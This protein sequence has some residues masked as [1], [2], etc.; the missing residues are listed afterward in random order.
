MP[1]I[2]AEPGSQIA[3]IIQQVAQKH[4]DSEKLKGFRECGKVIA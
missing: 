1:E 3:K 2:K 4:K